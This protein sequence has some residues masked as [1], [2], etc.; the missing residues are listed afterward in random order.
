MLL[1]RRNNI[2]DSKVLTEILSFINYCCHWS[3]LQVRS[4]ARC[5]VPVWVTRLLLDRRN[6]VQDTKVLTELLSLIPTCLI[7]SL[8]EFPFAVKVYLSWASGLSLINYHYVLLPI[9]SFKIKI[10]RAIRCF[11]LERLYCDIISFFVLGGQ[12]PDSLIILWR[13]LFLFGLP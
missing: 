2:Q 5:K 9:R 12:V 8:I 11:Y 7:H 3:V 6:H 13:T 10:G 4:H 1:Y